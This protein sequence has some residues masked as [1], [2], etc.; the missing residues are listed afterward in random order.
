MTMKEPTLEDLAPHIVGSKVCRVCGLMSSNLK[1][2][3][4]LHE[5][6]LMSDQSVASSVEWMNAQLDEFRRDGVLNEDQTRHFSVHSAR[7]HFNKH[8][9]TVEIFQRLLKAALNVQSSKP[10]DEATIDAHRELQERYGL[11]WDAVDEF[12][13]LREL[14]QAAE[15][16]ISMYDARLR[17]QES[18]PGY[19]VDFKAIKEFQLLVSDHIKNR[20]ELLRLQNSMQVSGKAVEAGIA[21]VAKAFI[22]EAARVSEEVKAMISREHPGSSVADDAEALIRN[23]LGETLKSIIQDAHSVVLKNYGIK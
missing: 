18:T 9:A 10:R 8:V 19:M 5:R 22:N 7:N 17:A 3:C 23:R 20:T 1:L 11:I 4:E 2:W 13:Q 12:V 16:R 15:M 14:L 6:V 21:A